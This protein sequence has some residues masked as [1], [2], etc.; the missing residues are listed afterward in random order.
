MLHSPMNRICPSLSWV[1]RSNTLRHMAG[2]KKGSSPSTTSISA[3][4][5]KSSFQKSMGPSLLRRGGG[6][7]CAAQ[8][9]E[10]VAPRVDDHQVGLAAKAR[11]IRTEAA[12]EG[13]EL[14]VAPERLGEQLRRFRI[15][16]ALHL[17]RVAIRLGDDHLAL[18]VG[19]GANLFALCRAGGA[20]FVGD[21]LALGLHPAIDRIGDG[22]REVDALD[23]HI[24]DLDAE[25]LRL[26]GESAAYVLHHLLA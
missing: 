25:G 26:V 12:I 19:V 1:A 14:R 18:P 21:A 6:R 4:A 8:S 11:P 23:A 2:L 20:Q 5:P 9:L 7:R 24:G 17:L 22:R 16:V 10:E 3:S 13:S 15:A